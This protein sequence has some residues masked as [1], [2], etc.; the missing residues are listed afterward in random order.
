MCKSLSRAT[1]AVTLA[2]IAGSGVLASDVAA[3]A[4]SSDA[5]A[6]PAAGAAPLVCPVSALTILEGVPSP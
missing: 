6:I 1:A 4:S 2:S 3:Q 5:N